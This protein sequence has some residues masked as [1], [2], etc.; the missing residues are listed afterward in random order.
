[1]EDSN[2]KWHTSST[3]TYSAEDLEQIRR[4]YNAKLSALESKLQVIENAVLPKSSTRCHISALMP[5]STDSSLERATPRQ[6]FELFES[7]LNAGPKKPDFRKLTSAWGILFSSLFLSPMEMQSEIQNKIS[8]ENLA[9]L[10]EVIKSD[11]ARQGRFVSDVIKKGEQIDRLALIL[12]ADLRD[13]GGIERDGVPAIHLLTRACDK[14][15]RPVLIE[16]A[17]KHLLSSVF[18]RDGMP[19]FFTIL[20]LGNLTIYD[21]NAIEKVF[22]KDDLRQV[23]VQ[24]RTG[25]NGLE[26]F[27]EI[28]TQMREKLALQ[29]KRLTTSCHK[30]NATYKGAVGPPKNIPVPD[31]NGKDMQAGEETGSPAEPGNDNKS[32][33]CQQDASSMSD[34]GDTP[35]KNKKIL[36]VDDNEIIRLL[37]LQRLNDLGYENCVQAKSGDEAVKLAEAARPYLIF[38]DIKMPGKLDGVA[39]AHKIKASLDTRIIFVTGSS[40]ED[41]LDRAKDVH[42]EGYILK[43]FDE[44]KLRVALQLLR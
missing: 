29:R 14:S 40:D 11:C 25:R 24:K 42:P 41:T 23:M 28:S 20:G 8:T 36:I 21:I 27:T 9:M 35:N 1:M 6:L 38:M 12:I 22:S 33:I 10:R 30:A 43:P 34:A 16:K 5:Q 13:L 31:E 26:A 15:I 44:T 32:T 7:S 18:D 4:D 37:L 19:V 3:V 2:E 39:A 17:G